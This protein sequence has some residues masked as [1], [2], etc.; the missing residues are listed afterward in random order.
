MFLGHIMFKSFMLMEGLLHNS[1]VHVFVKI[2][3]ERT[4]NVPVHYTKSVNSFYE[5]SSIFDCSF[6]YGISPSSK[7]RSSKSNTTNFKIIAFR[8]L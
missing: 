2:L 6:S 1:I 7:E 3:L 5:D 8:E 4:N